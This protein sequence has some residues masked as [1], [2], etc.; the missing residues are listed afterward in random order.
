MTRAGPPPKKT[1]TPYS[2]VSLPFPTDGRPSLVQLR[3]PALS[4]IWPSA[5]KNNAD[6][7]LPRP[8]F[9]GSHYDHHPFASVS[10]LHPPL[11]FLATPSFIFGL[12]PFCLSVACAWT[13]RSRLKT[14]LCVPD[15][16]LVQHNRWTD[17]LGHFCDSS[18]EP[19][20]ARLPAA[21]GA[22]A[23]SLWHF[24]LW[25]HLR[26]TCPPTRLPVRL[27]SFFLMPATTTTMPDTKTT[28]ED[29][30]RACLWYTVRSEAPRGLSSAF[31]SVIPPI[32]WAS[33][34]H[35][36]LQA[37]SVNSKAGGA[38]HLLS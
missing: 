22:V 30:Y 36:S 12:A 6:A 29:E 38:S 37:S 10:L 34:R 8:A 16:D 3:S 35:H 23:A 21:A 14:G 13:V 26:V 7:R 20:L 4:I 2:I 5:S 11:T 9:H 25:W 17:G 32:L 15:A 28:Q 31:A 24:P 18:T 27:A 1:T 19:A 33:R